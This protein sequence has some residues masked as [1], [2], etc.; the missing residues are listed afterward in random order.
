M[1]ETVERE[2]VVKRVDAHYAISNAMTIETDFDRCGPT[3]PA[4]ALTA[5]LHEPGPAFSFKSVF[6]DDTKSASGNYRRARAMHLLAAA[7]GRLQPRDLFRILRDH[8]EGPP[9]DGRPGSRICAHR[10]E[11]PIGQ[12]TA[13]WVADLSSRRIVHWVTGTAA[14]CTSLFKPVLL[15]AGL[16]DHG[17]QPGEQADANTL[18]WRHEQLRKLLDG[19]DSATRDAFL[20]ER[21]ALEERFLDDVAQCPAIIDRTSGEQARR[22]VEACWQDAGAFEAKWY[23]RLGRSRQPR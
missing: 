12:T 15:E 11:N 22:V 20:A 2:W 10:S 23:S 1:L 17:P 8:Q 5:R 3:L 13:S 6:E 16:P 7:S 21:N 4:R 18:W 19:S 9:I 14:P